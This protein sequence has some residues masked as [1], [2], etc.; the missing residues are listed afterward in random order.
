MKIGRSFDR[1]IIYNLP[2]KRTLE[3]PGAKVACQKYSISPRNG[4]SML[5]YW[6]EATHRKYSLSANMSTDFQ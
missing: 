2:L 1:R 3:N 5:S 4:S 6:V